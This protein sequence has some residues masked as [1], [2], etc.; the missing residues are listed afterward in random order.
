MIKLD[1]PISEEKIRELKAEFFQA[2]G[3]QSRGMGEDSGGFV[4]QLLPGFKQGLPYF[5]KQCH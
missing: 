1:I 5:M 2:L 3:G 4:D